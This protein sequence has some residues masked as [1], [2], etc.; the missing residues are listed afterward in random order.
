M[1]FIAL[2]AAVDWVTLITAIMSVAYAVS[3]LFAAFGKKDIAEDIEVKVS[4]V[5]KFFQVIMANY[6]AAANV[7]NSYRK[8]EGEKPED[9]VKE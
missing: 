7:K 1:E 8:T 4:G 9:I 5:E 3:H 6:G 2:L